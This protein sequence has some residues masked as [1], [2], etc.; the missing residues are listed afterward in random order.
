VNVLQFKSNLSS[1]TKRLGHPDRYYRSL[2]FSIDLSSHLVFSFVSLL[3]DFLRRQ[4]LVPVSS[5]R[6][7]RLSLPVVF[8]RAAGERLSDF[9]C[10]SVIHVHTRVFRRCCC[11]LRSRRAACSP[12]ARFIFSSLDSASA[13]IRSTGFRP[14]VH[15][16]VSPA[17]DSSPLVFGSSAL[18]FFDSIGFHFCALSCLPPGLDSCATSD[19]GQRAQAFFFSCSSSFCG[20]AASFVL[21]VF[22]W[23]CLSFCDY[24]YCRFGC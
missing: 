21:W 11:T 24:C 5:L 20:L 6:F 15:P 16:A 18:G 10:C 3:R 8:G 1:L 14:R 19:V 2:Y 7:P 9:C 12:A 13:P 4:F 17:R 23:I 22:P